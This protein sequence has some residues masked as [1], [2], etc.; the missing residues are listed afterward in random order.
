VGAVS[1]EEKRKQKRAIRRL[2]REV[3]KRDV[4]RVAEWEA[5]GVHVKLD[6]YGH[7]KGEAKEPW[8]KLR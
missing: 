8:W 6:K 7:W 4:A 1:R 5:S 2:R 3:V